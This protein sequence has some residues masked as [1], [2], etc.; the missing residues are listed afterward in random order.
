MYPSR[1]RTGLLSP[2][3]TWRGSVTMIEVS[4]RPQYSRTLSGDESH[5]E[6]V[7]GAPFAASGPARLAGER[8]RGAPRG[9]GANDPPRRGAAAGAGVSGGV[10]ERS[11]RRL[12]ATRRE[13]DAPAAARRRGGD[14]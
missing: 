12:P 2:S 5:R 1:L 10:A 4:F 3:L 11:G 9:V 13:R 7:A 8:T 6:P 14:R